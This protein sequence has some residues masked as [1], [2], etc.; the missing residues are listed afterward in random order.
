MR[1][2]KIHRRNTYYPWI[3]RTTRVKKT[4]TIPCSWDR[5]PSV[6]VLAL[7]LSGVTSWQTLSERHFYL[8]RSSSGTQQNNDNSDCRSHGNCAKGHFE[9]GV[10]RRAEQTA[11]RV[12]YQALERVGQNATRARDAAIARMRRPNLVAGQRKN[13]LKNKSFQ[14]RT[15]SC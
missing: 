5:K 7:I 14:R 11:E 8:K 2:E 6:L 13:S 3:V 12:K 10:V 4:R 9:L 1:K 15:M